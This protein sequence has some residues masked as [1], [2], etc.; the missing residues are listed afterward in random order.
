MTMINQFESFSQ[1]YYKNASSDHYTAVEILRR[2]LQN[3]LPNT[4]S[5]S[6]PGLKGV[7]TI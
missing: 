4:A 3:I 2:I 5:T 6:T 1:T 7:F